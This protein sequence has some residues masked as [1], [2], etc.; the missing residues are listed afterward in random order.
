MSADK[1]QLLAKKSRLVGL[2]I[3]GAMVLWI[4]AQ[5]IGGAL[6]LE[7]RYVFLFDLLA[8]AAFI[9]ALAVSYQ[10]WRARQAD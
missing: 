5:T 9:W 1:D 10:I 7:S 2:V 3:A 4:G 8:I 6:G